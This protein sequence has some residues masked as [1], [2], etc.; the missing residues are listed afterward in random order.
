MQF[1]YFHKIN[2]PKRWTAIPS[3]LVDHFTWKE[4]IKFRISKSEKYY[5][6]ANVVQQEKKAGLCPEYL[7]VSSE[8]SASHLNLI[9]A[10]S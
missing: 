7:K 2:G 10:I 9:S 1:T 8:N 4:L 3:I 5:L 6:G